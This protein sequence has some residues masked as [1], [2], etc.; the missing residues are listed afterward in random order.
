MEDPVKQPVPLRLVFQGSVPVET[1]LEGE[2][3]YRQFS[4][5]VRNYDPKSTLNGQIMKMLEPCCGD[6]AKA[7]LPG[8]VL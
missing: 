5:M 4:E 6:R 2:E 7:Q 8:R 1:A 3:L